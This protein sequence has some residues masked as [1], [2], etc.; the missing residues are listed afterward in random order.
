MKEVCLQ[1]DRTLFD[2][3]IDRIT[4]QGVSFKGKNKINIAGRK[5]L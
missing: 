1:G 3:H 5:V 4:F 2:G